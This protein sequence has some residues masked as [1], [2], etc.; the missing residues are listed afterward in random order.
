MARTAI[1]LVIG[2]MALGACGGGPTGEAKAKKDEA[3]GGLDLRRIVG[4]VKNPPDEFAVISKKPLEMPQDFAALPPPNPG[5]RSTRAPDPIAEARAALLNDAAGGTAATAQTST[6]EAALLNASGASDPNIRATLAADQTD[7]EAEQ[8]Q[9]VLD[10][11]FPALK[12]LRGEDTRG[13]IDPTDE[14]QRLNTVA[15]TPAARAAR[16]APIATIPSNPVPATLAT[17]A[18][19]APSATATPVTTLPAAPP[20]VTRQAPGTD[21]ELIFIPE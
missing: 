12:R 9:Y 10:R 3:T 8:E 18:P 7:Y 15:A 20:P 13:I 1:I 11:Y 4:T 6:S 21:G 17:P 16:S 2:A 5:E 14:Y 19:A